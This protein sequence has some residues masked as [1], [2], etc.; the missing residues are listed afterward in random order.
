MTRLSHVVSACAGAVVAGSLFVAIGLGPAQ[1][2][3][4]GNPTPPATPP[5]APRTTPPTAPKAPPRGGAATTPPG[6]ESIPSP[7]DPGKPGV[8]P[9]PPEVAAAM[10]MMNPCPQHEWL[11]QRV[12]TWTGSGK[13]FMAPDQPME[14]NGVST[15]RMILGGRYLVEEV[16]S[17]M[18]GEPFE[19]FGITAYNRQTN[20]FQLAWLDT[21]G[22]AIT[23]GNGNRSA[24]GK[25]LN[26]TMATFDPM[27]NKDVTMRMVQTD[28]DNDTFTT[29][30]FGPGP[31]GTE[32]KMMELTYRRKK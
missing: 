25:K 29:E 14:F 4:A 6:K 13:M 12:G 5:T 2:T 9:M 24:D 8:V 17:T 23:E 3:G 21:M 10:E 31:N 28:V 22:T 20:K 18:A 19:A 32:M 30:M 1:G 7:Q 27:T 26:I 16:K 15:F 11:A